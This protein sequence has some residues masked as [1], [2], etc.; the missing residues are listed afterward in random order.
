MSSWPGPIGAV[1]M[2]VEDLATCKT[3]YSKAFDLPVH[4]EDDDSVVFV[5]VDEVDATA[6]Q[7]VETPRHL[8]QRPDGPTVGHSDGKLP[9]PG[10]AYLG[11]R[12]LVP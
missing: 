4:D 6:A 7:L 9:G 10:R 11:D 3:F 2:F 5:G 1:T 12:S 8:A